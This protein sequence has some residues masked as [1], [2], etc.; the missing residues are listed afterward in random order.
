MAEFLKDFDIQGHPSCSAIG[1]S[2]KLNA[3]GIRLCW[4][5]TRTITIITRTI[6]H[7]KNPE[8]YILT[9]HALCRRSAQKPADEL[10][11]AFKLAHPDV[12]PGTVAESSSAPVHRTLSDPGVMSNS[13]LEHRYQLFLRIRH[14]IGFSYMHRR[15]LC[16]FH[17]FPTGKKVAC[18]LIYLA[19]DLDNS[20]IMRTIRTTTEPLERPMIIG[21]SLRTSWTRIPLYF[22]R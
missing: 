17:T 11:E 18:Q 19:L 15:R 10:Y 7:Q 4:Q 6:Y 12:G 14:S 9:D 13:L 8:S 1:T 2:P 3:V 21:D 22:L 16:C 5:R 20:R